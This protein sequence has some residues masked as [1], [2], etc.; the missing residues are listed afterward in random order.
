M[1]IKWEDEDQKRKSHF[2]TK[3]GYY[4]VIRYFYTVFTMLR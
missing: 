3:R 2:A 1:E 4:S